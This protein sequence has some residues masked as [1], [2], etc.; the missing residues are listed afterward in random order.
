MKRFYNLV[1][2]ALAVLIIPMAS[3]FG[4]MTV[5]QFTSSS[6]SQISLSSPSTLLGSG[7]DDVASGVFNIGFNFDFNGTTYSQL[8]VPPTRS[9]REAPMGS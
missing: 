9:S 2:S 8:M 7:N 3:S 4:A 5:Y 6:G 1:L